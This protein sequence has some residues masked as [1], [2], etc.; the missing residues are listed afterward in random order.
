MNN[1]IPTEYLAGLTLEKQ[2]EIKRIWKLHN[3]LMVRLK[4]VLE[5]QLESVQI[6]NEKDY[7]RP[8][9]PYWRAN[10]DGQIQMLLTILQLLPDQR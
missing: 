7:D 8:G 10:Q 3:P 9:W 5:K 2:A 6:S 1:R 4:E